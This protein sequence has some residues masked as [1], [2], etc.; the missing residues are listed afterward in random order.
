MIAEIGFNNMPNLVTDTFKSLKYNYPQVKAILWWDEDWSDS[1]FGVHSR[2][3]SS[4]ENL[5]AFKDSLADPYF[6]NRIP[7][8]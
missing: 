8:R 1:E 6:L 3:D 7:Y 2:I 5:K 4:P